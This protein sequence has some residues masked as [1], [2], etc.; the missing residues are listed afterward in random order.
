MHS[1][2]NRSMVLISYGWNGEAYA[3]PP[4]AWGRDD[5]W[6]RRA[7]EMMVGSM[8]GFTSLRGCSTVLLCPLSLGWSVVATVPTWSRHNPGSVFAQALSS[9]QIPWPFSLAHV[10][11]WMHK[12]ERGTRK[13]ESFNLY[14]KVTEHMAFLISIEYLI[15]RT[16]L[17]KVASMSWCYKK[18]KMADQKNGNLVP[19]LT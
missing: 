16:T 2:G 19:K 10:L 15:N 8:E 5:W 17:N 1:S 14:L 6:R 3:F 18:P 7:W 12:Y 13:Q 9:P 4:L 11:F